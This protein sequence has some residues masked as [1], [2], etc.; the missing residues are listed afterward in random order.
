[1]AANVSTQM[2]K[3]L[4]QL[5]EMCHQGWTMHVKLMSVA[6]PA[7]TATQIQ[8]PFSEHHAKPCTGY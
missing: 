4:I 7:P 2:R 3:D 1:M 8:R 5:Y 6:Q